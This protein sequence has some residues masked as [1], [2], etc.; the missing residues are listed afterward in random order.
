VVKY[1]HNK[2]DDYN[3]VQISGIKQ[4]HNLAICAATGTAP[5][6]IFI[7][8]N[9]LYP[10]NNNSPTGG[11][12]MASGT[13]LQTAWAPWIR[14]LAEILETHLAEVKHQGETKLQHSEPLAH[15]SLL[16]AMITKRTAGLLH[17]KLLPHRPTELRLSQAP[18]LQAYQAPATQ[19]HRPVGLPGHH[20][21]AHQAAAPPGSC[22]PL[23]Q[24]PALQ[25]CWTPTHPVPTTG[26]L[27]CHQTLAPNLP[28]RHRQD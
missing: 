6:R 19:G 2:I 3:D 5:Y 8:F 9:Q 22:P 10:L 25:A 17:A 1:I 26:R 23:H 13:Q 27:Q 28:R 14:D 7:F 16:H 11:S 12:K 4:T 24:A 20:P 15:G 18:T 21:L